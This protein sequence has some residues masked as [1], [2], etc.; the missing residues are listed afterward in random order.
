MEGYAAAGA[1]ATVES[2]CVKPQT[3]GSSLVLVVSA[4]TGSAQHITGKFAMTVATVTVGC[5]SV[6]KAGLEK[7]ASFR[8]SVAY[9]ARRA[10]S[11]A[12]TNRG[13]SVPTEG[14][15][16]VGA[17]CVTKMTTRA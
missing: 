1:N 3:R 15:V 6:T 4:T 13:W 12:K 5:V 11:C 14:P 7:L 2:A 8:R 16:T 10:E 9:Q 17:A